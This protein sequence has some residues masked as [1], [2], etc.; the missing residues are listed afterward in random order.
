[1]SYFDTAYLLKC[2]VKEH[3]WE[4]VWAFVDAVNARDRD[5]LDRLAVAVGGDRIAQ[6]I[7]MLRWIPRRRRQAE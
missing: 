3:G 4:A 1:M 5:A 7:P 6:A 2:Y